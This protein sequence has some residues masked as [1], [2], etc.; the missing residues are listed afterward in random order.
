MRSA[1][2]CAAAR[3]ISRSSM[4]CSMPRPRLAVPGAP[5]RSAR[6]R[7]FDQRRPARAAAR[8]LL[9]SSPARPVYGDD[10]APA[11]ALWLK[12]VRSPHAHA[13]FAIGDLA[14]FLATQSR[15]RAHVHGRTMCRARIRSASI[16]T[17]RTSRCSRE[18]HV[19][20][21]GEPVL[22]LAGT[23]E[24]VE[25]VHAADLPIVWEPLPALHGI[26]AAL[27]RGAPAIH[28]EQARQHADA[29]RRSSRA[30]PCASSD[31]RG[32]Y[33]GGHVRNLL[34]RAR[35]HR[36][37]GRLGQR[38]GD[39]I[40]VYAC[41]Q[42]PEHG[43]RRDRARARACRAKASA[44]CPRPA[45]AASA[46]SSTSSLQPMLA[47]A[48]WHLD[49]PV[50]C[51][52]ERI[53]SMAST[54]KRHPAS[55]RARASC[56][57]DGRLV[58][59]EFGRR[60]QHRRL[61]L[62]GADGGR[63]RARARRRPLPCSAR[64]EPCP[65]DLHQRHAGRRLPRLRRAAGRHRARGADGRPRG[66]SR[67]RPAR[68]PPHQCAARRRHDAQRPDARSQRRSRR[69]PRCAEAPLAGPAGASRGTQRRS[70]APCAAASASAAC[71]T[72]SATPPCPTPPPCA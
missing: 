46:A 5:P 39:R 70:P 43:P 32:A 60:F 41:T 1:A 72:A 54:T 53:E 8:W 29:R 21:R 63:P 55:I 66:E 50:R 51:V 56:D 24:A 62:L 15:H 6:C 69:L 47:V 31:N 42:A 59:Y 13:R 4:R 30:T 33:G 27:A 22:A 48:A 11:D 25:A 49:R 68:V 12:A 38:V 37:R 9:P 35:L 57:A 7:V 61:R 52:Y 26:E 14:P 17:S 45:A 67:P 58:A 18:A 65:R 10:G 16:P 71:G 28:A 19:R 36:A 23:R 64:Q 3:A 40:E 44:S 2:C 20:H 34:R